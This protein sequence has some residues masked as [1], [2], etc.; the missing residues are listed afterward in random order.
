MQGYDVSKLKNFEPSNCKPYKSLTGKR[1]GTLTVRVL[2]GRISNTHNKVAVYGCECDCGG[3]AVL[4]ANQIRSNKTLKCLECDRQIG[5]KVV[6]RIRKKMQGYKVC[7][8]KRSRE[9]SLTYEQ[10]EKYCLSDCVYCGNSPNPINGVDRVDNSKG[11]IESNCVPCCTQCN[12]AKCEL[13]QEEFLI[14]ICRIHN[15]L[16][17][18]GRLF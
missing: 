8:K 1:V 12:M 4:T 17:K 7:A 5:W 13:E 9:W 16:S 15:N 2:L 10:F 6:A 11:Y 3:K 18:K 14:Q